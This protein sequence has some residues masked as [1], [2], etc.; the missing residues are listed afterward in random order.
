MTM[1]NFL[2]SFIILV[3]II[4]SLGAQDIKNLPSYKRFFYPELSPILHK[5]NKSEKATSNFIFFR[6]GSF[7]SSIQS[8][9]NQSWG[10]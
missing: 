10:E 9:V 8:V 1:N 3:L 4:G 6:I 7:K 5:Y 2:I